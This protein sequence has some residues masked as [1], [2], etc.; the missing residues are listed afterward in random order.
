MTPAQ[1][2][3]QL[4]QSSPWGESQVPSPHTGGQTPQSL[5]QVLQSSSGSQLPLPQTGGQTPQSL[6]QVVQL[7]P[8]AASQAPSPHTGWHAPQ[9]W[10]QLEQLSPAS[11]WPSPHAVGQLPP[12]WFL[13]S[14]TQVS[15]HAVEQQ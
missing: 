3:L 7:S 5:L 15:S 4:A 10:A 6:A 13:H 14:P 9:S 11:H 8:K 1:S 2:I 12:H